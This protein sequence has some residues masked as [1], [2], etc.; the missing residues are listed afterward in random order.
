MCFSATASFGVGAVLLTSGVATMKKVKEPNLIPFASI[1]LIFAAHQITE[2]MLWLALTGTA[3]SGWENQ[4]TYAY[5]II[6]QILWPIT[7]PIAMVLIEK[8]VVRR[9]ILLGMVCLGA[10]AAIYRS[11]TLTIYGVEATILENHI[12]YEIDKI[13]S[14]TRVGLFI[15]FIT[16]TMPLLI[17]SVK[18]A[19]IVGILILASYI[20]TFILYKEFTPSVWCF[21]GAVISILLL[22]M[23]KDIQKAMK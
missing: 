15:Y 18:R 11:Y 23:I 9:K 7:L 8:E 22:F 20:V 1:P 3:L 10:L 6:A 17:S 14:Y 4:L 16:T 12:F 5:I 19:W 21:F 2:G 13:N